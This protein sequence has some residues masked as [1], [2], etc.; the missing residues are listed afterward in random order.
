LEAALA[1]INLRA[2]IVLCGM[3]SQYNATKRVPGPSNLARLITQRARMEGFL[4]T[5]YYKRFGEAVSD[6]AQWLAQGNI[7]YRVDIVEGL[8]Q[9]PVAINRLFDGSNKGKLIVKI[10]EEPVR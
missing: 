8:E 3:I 9:A 6:L 1:R 4:V 10:S 7:Q 5:D 2:R